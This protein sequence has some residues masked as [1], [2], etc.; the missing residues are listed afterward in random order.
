[1]RKARHYT[2]TEEFQ[3]AAKAIADA[4]RFLGYAQQLHPPGEG[5]A[6]ATEAKAMLLDVDRVVVL[7]INGARRDIEARRAKV[8]PYSADDIED[9]QIGPIW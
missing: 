1:M 9:F 3:R 8:S 2:Q 4:R 6:C 5:T 7:G